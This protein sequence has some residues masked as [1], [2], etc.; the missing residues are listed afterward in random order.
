MLKNRTIWICVFAIFLGGASECTMA[1]WSSGYLEQ[2]L[3]IPKVWGDI[4]GV[5]LFAVMLGLGR[6]LYAKIGK[7]IEKVLFMGVIGTTICYLITA[8]SSMPII[9]LIACGFTGF[10]VSM[11]WPGSLI[12]A[13]KRIPSGGVFI[14]AMMAAGGDLGASVG[15]QLVGIITDVVIKSNGMIQFANK[16]G[17]TPEQ[18]GMKLGMFT[19]MI[20]PL[21]GIFIFLYILKSSYKERRNV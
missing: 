10:C 15:P 20:F 18:L 3:N 14:Y 21:V 16:F 17:F 1:Q 4:F 7:N 12:V 6:S 11:L 13:S 2:A 9:G 19:G 8:I 5:A